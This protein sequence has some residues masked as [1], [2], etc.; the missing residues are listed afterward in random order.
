MANAQ[1]VNIPDANFKA[2]LLS[3]SPSNQIA[4]IETTNSIGHVSSYNVIDTNGDGEIQ[5]WEAEAIKYLN[6]SSSTISNLAGIEN[7]IN[8]QTLYCGSNLLASI[9]V[10]QN[11]NLKRLN[12][13]INQFTN[14]DVTQNV[15][16]KYLS[17]YS[18]LLANIDVT[19]NSNLI[20]FSCGRNQ[21]TNLNVTQNPNIT[22][23]SCDSNQ[24]TSID[25]TQN[26]NLNNLFIYSNQLTSLDLTQ[27]PNLNVL[28]CT[29]NQL[30]TLNLTQNTGLRVLECNNNLLTD[31]DL[32]Q[33]IDLRILY[34][35]SN[36]LTSLDVS[37]NISLIWLYCSNNQLTNLD[38]SQNIDLTILH[39]STNQL[40]TL[41]LNSNINL[42]TLSC[43]NN[44]FVNLDILANSALNFLICKDMPTLEAIFMKNN[45]ATAWTTLD[46]SSNP[47]LEFVCCNTD[48]LSL[49][50]Q[51]I[52][53]YAYTGCQA[54]NLTCNYPFIYEVRGNTHYD[55]YD[56]GCNEAIDDYV[57]PN[58]KYE[59]FDGTSTL[60]TSGNQLG[61]YFIPLEAGNYTITPVIE[62]PNYFNVTPSSFAINFPSD[63]TPF[64]QNICL[65]WNE[66]DYFDDLEVT[67]LPI[68]PARPGFEAVYKVLVRNKGFDNTNGTVT[69]TYDNSILDYVTSIPAYTSSNT[70]S[71]SWDFYSEPFL[72]LEY[73][74]AFN[75][76]SSSD[77]PAVNINDEI[78]F[79][80]TVV[81]DWTDY[82]QD[83]NTFTLDQTVVGSYD[84]NDKTCLQGE[85]EEV[86]IVGEY[87]HYLI[88]FENTGTYAAEKVVIEDVIDTSKFDISTLIPIDASHSYYT[89]ITG[90]VVEFV[91]DNINLD[92]ND[93][94][95]DGYIAFKIKLLSTLNVGDTFTNN[96][97]IF[98]DSNPAIITNTYV[99]TIVAPLSNQ[100]FNENEFV[101]FPNPA[102]EVLNI[103]SNNNLEINS[104]EIYNLLGQV[105]LVVPTSSTA[106]DVSSLKTGTYFIKVNTNNG[107][108]NAK[109]IKK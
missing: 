103:Q 83:D 2:K 97:S 31:I 81:H 12:C 37:H 67:I 17:C 68:T 105:V 9:D 55:Y 74:V 18:N 95:N 75:L 60:I 49:V 1:I 5:I 20:H 109:F 73:D 16:L 54:S 41:D 32:T 44:L 36:Q 3:A 84:P 38:L 82:T 29:N 63:P 87:V 34:C 104:I 85:T 35:D 57:V 21:L 64:V 77:T 22:S 100:S 102:K 90:N 94:N 92:F 40:S 25:I 27:N 88:R 101:I 108:A 58:V 48:D 52:L 98:F 70:N 14:L 65:T 15:N 43:Y 50:Q 96:A 78:N 69:L 28:E 8:L 51:K 72:T 80:A 42:I 11:L 62:N 59:I 4:S 99:T 106:I 46:F 19:Q 53:D 61:E 45:N 13:E 24:L 33:N 91:F 26:P 93:P 56:D 7:F 71:I 89:K 66:L 86:D 47:N 6:V 30:T 79:T 23:L 107:S 39:C 76:N 10:T